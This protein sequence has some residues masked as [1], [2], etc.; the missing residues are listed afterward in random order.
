[1]DDIVIIIIFQASRKLQSMYLSSNY[2]TMLPSSLFSNHRGL[3][4]VD[5][6]GNLLT[7]L[8]EQLFQRTSLEIF[9]ASS[10]RLTEIPIKV[11]Q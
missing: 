8:P 3:K 7:S 1:M 10:N 2:L 5:V 4:L 11:C 6:S 9:R